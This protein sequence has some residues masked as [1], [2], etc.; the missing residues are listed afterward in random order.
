MILRS[1]V[2]GFVALVALVA[3]VPAT[4]SAITAFANT[5][6]AAGAATGDLSIVATDRLGRPLVGA[7]VAIDG[8]TAV[9]DHWGRALLA[10]VEPGPVTVTHVRYL[11]RTVEWTGAGDRFRVVLASPLVRGLHVAGGLPGTARWQELLAIADATAINAVV[12]DMKA[13]AGNVYPT[14]ASSWAHAA[15]AVLG[16]WELPTVVDQLH[17]RSLAVVVRIVAFQDPIAGVRLPSLSAWN[18]VTGAPLTRS[19][20]LFLDPTDVDARAYVLQLA[21]EACAAGVDEVQFDYVRFPDGSK[22]GIRFD[23]GDGTDESVRV[24]AITTFLAEAR[25]RL[26][27]DCRVGA[28]IFGFITSIPGD[29]GIGQRLEDLAAEVDVVSPMV[30]PDLWSEGWFGFTEPADHP[31]EVVSASMRNAV[32]RVGSVT[33]LRPW[34]Q[35]FG[36]YDAGEVRAQIQAADALG[37]G[38]M[39]WNA[40]SVFTPGAIPTDAELS[41]TAESPDPVHETLPD[42]GFWDVGNGTALAGDIAWLKSVEITRG[43]NAPWGDEY[44]PGRRLSRA[45]AAALLVRALDLPSSPTD[46]FA[47]DNGITHEADIDALAA[48]GI[49]LGCGAG[50]F[51]P[52]QL[53]DRAEMAGLVARALDLPHVEGDTF[54]DDDGITHEADIERLAAAGITNGCDT[55]RYCPGA[56]ITRAETAAFLHRALA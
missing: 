1:V 54:A 30:Y 14:S 42:S 5:S 35:D 6:P 34:L 40:T 38:W 44:C 27:A 28:D 25:A 16:W 23:G 22:A 43:C 56:A 55:D 2:A 8:R 10:D 41:A 26:P 21:D 50:R 18:T 31:A 32:D 36:G 13:E 29:G 49:T 46:W 24:A 39:V 9:T 20:Q 45:E 53:I 3:A 47:D 51:C 7:E 4:T 12:L 37:M 52:G 48:A 15:N 19:G 17:A 33:E 11:A